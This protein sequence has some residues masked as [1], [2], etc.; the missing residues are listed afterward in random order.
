MSEPS[1]YNQLA[2]ESL[3]ELTVTQLNSG[4][5]VTAVDRATINYWK[6]P[7][8]LSRIVQS[9][10]TYPWGLPIPEAGAVLVTDPCQPS[11]SLTIQPS[12]TELWQIA[13][14]SGVAAAAPAVLDISWYDGSNNVLMVSQQT[15]Q[16]T[17][18][19]IDINEKVSAPFVLSNSL[20]LNVE[21]TAGNSACL[22]K[23]AYHKVS[24]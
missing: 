18:T 21:E 14:I 5:S 17:E 4:S 12:G 10:R 6:G 2:K 16:T 24:L 9:S 11:E 7:I 22:L 8:T 19:M 20:Y 13:G 3:S 1:I 23:V 15:I